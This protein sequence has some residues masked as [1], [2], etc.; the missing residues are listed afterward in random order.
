MQIVVAFERTA[1]IDAG[2]ELRRLVRRQLGRQTPGIET[3]IGA[4]AVRRF[5]RG[6]IDSANCA[7]EIP[8]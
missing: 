4:L 8:V 3:A 7:H 6:K 5:A 1:M 2:I